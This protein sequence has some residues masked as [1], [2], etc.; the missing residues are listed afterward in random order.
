[1]T[2]PNKPHPIIPIIT[3][4]M[5]GVSAGLPL[6]LIFSTLSLWLLEAGVQRSMVTMF[7]WAALG[8]SFKFVWSPLMDSLT[9]PVLTRT[10]GKRRSWLLLA[11][12][13]MISA[14][15][16]MAFANPNP[17]HLPSLQMMAVGA[18]LLG[19]SSATQDVAIDAYRIEIA[20]NNTAMQSN[21]SA[22]Y[23]AG[24]RLGM[25]V[26]GAGSL[27]IATYLGSSKEHYLYEAWRNT[28]LIMAAT[29]GLGV[30]TTLCIREP[31]VS[32][33]TPRLSVWNNVRLLAMFVCVVMAFVLSYA[34]SGEVITQL[35]QGATDT[36][37][38]QFL[39]ETLHF[40]IS[41]VAAVF[42]GWWAV[43]IKIVDK[44]IAIQTWVSPITEFFQRYGKRAFVLLALIGLYR[45]SDIVSGVISN[46]FY[47]DLGFTKDEIASAVKIFGVVMSIFG[48]FVGGV[49]AQKFR[50]M[51][52]MMMGAIAAAATNLLFILLAMRG[53]DVHLMYTAVGLDNFAAG[54]AGTVFVAFLSSLTNIRFTA[55]QY[56][57]FSSLM[58]LF[59]KVLGGYSGGIVDSI[60]YMGFFAFTALLGVPILVLVWW[61]DR[62][63]FPKNKDS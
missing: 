3:L 36:P 8:Y 11:Q 49:L 13:L 16:I 15:L 62:V 24:Y 42:V 17:N 5:L 44:P 4:T 48:G 19:F 21:L 30:I 28:Y 23:T 32:H 47:T 10:L 58:T 40:A 14:V 51:N 33:Q 37:L 55:V 60:G 26:S 38:T 27:L 6:L 7:S 25:V 45:I 53:H 9:L 46:V 22:A 20:P 57:L 35:K 1:M 31:E 61:A 43:A 52:M 12:C 63:L 18:V 41:L 50:I 39:W 29:M 2:A 34:Y 59:P 54:L 56:A